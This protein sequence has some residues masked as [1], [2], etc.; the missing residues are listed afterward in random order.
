MTASGPEGPP[1]PS[2]PGPPA[3][4]H[5]PRSLLWVCECGCGFPGP[6]ELQGSGVGRGAL[7]LGLQLRKV[8]SGRAGCAVPSQGSSPGAGDREPAPASPW[9]Q[10]QPEVQGLEHLCCGLEQ[11]LMQAVPHSWYS[12]LAGHWPTAEEAQGCERPH[13]GQAAQPPQGG[14]PVA[15]PSP[16]PSCRDSQ[17][18]PGPRQLLTGLCAMLHRREYSDRVA[19]LQFCWPGWAHAAMSA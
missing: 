9:G 11:V 10:K 13:P 17:Q 1:V 16:T 8:G 6:W 4:S 5:R 12:W 19:Q 15:P 14:L 2:V 3:L 7:G 18:R